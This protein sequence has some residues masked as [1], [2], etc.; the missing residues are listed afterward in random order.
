MSDSIND[1][2][3][4]TKRGDAGRTR[5]F[6]GEEVSKASSR[7]EAYGD[8]DELVSVLGLAKV[9]VGHPAL[10]GRLEQLQREL[11]IVGTEL[12]MSTE[13]R[14][15]L[16]ERIGADH[17]ERLT[18]AA[19]E[20]EGSIPS[21]TGFVLPGGTE[22]AAVLDIARTVSRRLERRVVDMADKGLV[23]NPHMLAW[24][25]RLSDYLWLLARLEEGE[26][27]IQK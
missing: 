6:S 17:A 9:K 8:L 16:S 26:Q 21:P 13:K 18:D 3:I 25:N 7:P 22:A 20:V 27:T 4:T 14:E 10:P 5:L 12:A 15:K 1:S 23:D 24:L 11:F 2:L 19:R